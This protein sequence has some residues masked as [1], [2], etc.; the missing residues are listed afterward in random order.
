VE[1]DASRRAKQLLP[2]RGFTQRGEDLRAVRK[3]LDTAVWT[4]A[5]AFLNEHF[6]L[7]GP[8]WLW[9]KFCRGLDLATL[10]ASPMHMRSN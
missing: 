3:V 8:P 5:A 2:T 6:T 7:T 10:P 1:F 9:G 4:Y